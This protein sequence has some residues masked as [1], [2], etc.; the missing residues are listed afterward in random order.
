MGRR[1]AYELG[2]VVDAASDL[3]WERG[4]RMTSIGDLEERTGLDRSSLYHAFGN[5]LGVFE[6]A[7]RRYVAEF[8]EGVEARLGTGV[9]L[10]PVIGFFAGMGQAFRSDPARYPRGCRM[11]N[12]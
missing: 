5:K 10:D 7:L 2:A 11:V 4:Y 6:A 8:G 12:T 9:G 3:F 1:P